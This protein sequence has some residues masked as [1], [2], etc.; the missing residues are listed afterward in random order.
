MPDFF[1]TAWRVVLAA[2]AVVAYA[3]FG[4]PAVANLDVDGSI[5]FALLGGACVLALV[6]ALFRSNTPSR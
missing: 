1:R 5:L 3:A 4:F 6:V 2:V